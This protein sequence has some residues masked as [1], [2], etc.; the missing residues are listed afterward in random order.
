M[1]PEEQAALREWV[2]P[3]AHLHGLMIQFPPGCIVRA[4]AGRELLV[5]APGHTGAVVSYTDDGNV[6]VI[7]KPARTITSPITGNTISPAAPIRATCDPDWL[8]V[9]R[10]STVTPEA[11]LEAIEN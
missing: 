3:L 9:V 10:Y 11:V 8:E 6:G 4:V 2:A 1:T 5:P 7:G